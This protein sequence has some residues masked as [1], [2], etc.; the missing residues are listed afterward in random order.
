MSAY[1]GDGDSAL[2][3]LRTALYLMPFEPLRHITFIGIGCAHFLAERYEQAARW[4]HD[5]VEASP[6]SF[7]ADRIAVA[8]TA[9]AGERS[10]ARR[11]ARNLMRNDPDLTVAEA[12]QAWPFTPA[13]MTRLGDG[14]EIAGLPRA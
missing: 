3:E 9:L 14:L 8:A 7:W 11:R 6:G 12:R 13:F 2:R 4:V 5:G 10:E 1:L